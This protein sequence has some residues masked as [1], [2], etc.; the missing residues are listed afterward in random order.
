MSLAPTSVYNASSDLPECLFVFVGRFLR[1]SL[2]CASTKAGN[3]KSDK[4]K[5]MKSGSAEPYVR[6]E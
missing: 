3:R 4:R 2:T 5:K 6:K 1:K